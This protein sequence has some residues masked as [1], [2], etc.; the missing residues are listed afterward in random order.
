MFSSSFIN[1]RYAA[2]C[3]SHSEVEVHE[4]E[5]AQ[6]V[7]TVME[8]LIAVSCCVGNLLV[9]VAVWSSRH[10]QQQPTYCLLLSLSVAD[11][12][13]GAVAIPLAVLVDGR[14]RTSFNFCLFISCLLILLTLSSVLSLTAIAVDRY[15]RVYTPIR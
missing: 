7:Y 6:V 14:V 4:M 8:V 2:D 10:L 3:G 9:M 11:A 12:L 15:L 13:V 5:A 1:R